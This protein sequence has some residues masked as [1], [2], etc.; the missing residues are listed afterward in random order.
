VPEI[1]QYTFKY[2]EVIEA[3]IKKAGLH[4]GKWQLTMNFGLGAANM[5]PS[6]NEVVP[7]AAVAVVSLGLTKA[8]PESPPALTLDAAEINPDLS[9]SG[10][11]RPSQ[12]SRG[13]AQESS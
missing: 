1:S 9:S 10:K 3:L 11:K 12:R 13:A 6:P 4:E 2:S 8:T 5:G 7:G